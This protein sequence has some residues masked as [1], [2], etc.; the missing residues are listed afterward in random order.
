MIAVLDTSLSAHS[1]PASTGVIIPVN[2]HLVGVSVEAVTLQR[3][4]EDWKVFGLKNSYNN[5]GS[6]N[7]GWREHTNCKRLPD[8]VQPQRFLH[9]CK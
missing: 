4:Y 6:D 7:G 3:Q 5:Y 8:G 9:L 2:R 1:T